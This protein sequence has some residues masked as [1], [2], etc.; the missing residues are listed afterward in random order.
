VTRRGEHLA[1]PGN[2]KAETDVDRS[3]T[4][5]EQQHRLVGTQAVEDARDPGILDPSQLA[6]TETLGKGRRGWASR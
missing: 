5:P 4:R 3:E 2:L 1:V 6:T